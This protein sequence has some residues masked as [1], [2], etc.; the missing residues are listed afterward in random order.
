VERNRD[1]GR[2]HDKGREGKGVES[3]EDRRQKLKNSEHST[4]HRLYI[5]IAWG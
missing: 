4:S 5:S 1:T 3:R 2:R